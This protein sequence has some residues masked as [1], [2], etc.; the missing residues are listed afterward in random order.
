VYR[1][2]QSH[3]ASK[4]SLANNAKN[5]SFKSN[6]LSR[7]GQEQISSKSL[8]A[9]APKRTLDQSAFDRDEYVQDPLTLGERIEREDSRQN[10][11]TLPHNEDGQKIRV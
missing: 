8:F 5:E 11:Q 9:N 10:F 7:Q 6:V 1:D 2:I 4:R 3:E